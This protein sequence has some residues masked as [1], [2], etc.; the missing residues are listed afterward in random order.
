MT[1]LTLAEL[2]GAGAIQNASNLTI[3]KADLP[4]LTASVNNRAEQ[5][6][7]AIILKAQ[8]QFQSI[9][10]DETGELIVD[11]NEQ[12]ISSDNSELYDLAVNYWRLIF[13]QINNQMYSNNQFTV[14]YYA[15]T[16]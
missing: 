16:D 12:S 6:L 13:T 7:V 1:D 8:Q 4:G 14:F 11:E 9:L 15:Q 5:L 2:F 10:V 3:Q